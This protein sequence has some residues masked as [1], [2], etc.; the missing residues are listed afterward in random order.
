MGET[1]PDN[2]DEILYGE[3]TSGEIHLASGNTITQLT[4][5]SAPT[6]GGTYE[7]AYD[8][9]GAAITQTVAADQSHPIPL[10]LIGCRF[11]KAVTTGGTG[12]DVE[13]TLKG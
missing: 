10:A 12:D 6:S 9:D 11:I 7:P 13:I 1:T 2:S 4:W 3:Y 5:Y 8:Y